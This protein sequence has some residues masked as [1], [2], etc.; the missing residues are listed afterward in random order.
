MGSLED[1]LNLSGAVSSGSMTL[2][3][4]MAMF[5]GIGS[6]G[7][8]MSVLHS[9]TESALLLLVGLTCVQAETRIFYSYHEM[10]SEN[11]GFAMKPL[12]R[13]VTYLVAGLHS[14][15][16][17]AL[18][19]REGGASPFFGFL[20]YLAC[21]ATLAGGL[22]SLWTWKQQRA[23]ASFNENCGADID[24]YYISS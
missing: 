6:L 13:A 20:W 22:T 16:V 4:V 23:L 14:V 18:V 9:L 12:G 1:V 17:R 19:W 24:S 5:E 21:L 10:V 15:G 3:G 2:L 11:F 7:R 8:K